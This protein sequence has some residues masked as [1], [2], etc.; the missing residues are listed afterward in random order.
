M[1]VFEALADMAQQNQEA[2]AFWTPIYGKC[3]DDATAN[4]IARLEA[5]NRAITEVM[6][7]IPIELAEREI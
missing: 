2:I 5:R 6:L 7:A 4:F 3:Q 1:K